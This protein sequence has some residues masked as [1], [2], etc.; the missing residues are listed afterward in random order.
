MQ[1][2]RGKVVLIVDDSTVTRDLIHKIVAPLVAEVHECG[3]GERAVAAFVAHRP[4][5]V[6]MDITMRGLNGIAA[7]LRIREVD[8]GARV[9]IVTNHDLPDLREAAMLAGA[10]GYVLKTNLLDLRRWLE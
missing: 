4:D 6:L 5:V 1:E 3:D 2:R 9:V 7:T 8:P 10:D